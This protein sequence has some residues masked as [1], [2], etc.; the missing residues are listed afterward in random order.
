M[1]DLFQIYDLDF[2]PTPL[3]KDDLGYGLKGMWLEV[4][5]IGQ[6]ITEH[7]APGRPGNIITGVRDA[8]RDMSVIA[9]LESMNSTDYL[10]K[11]DRVYSFF[12][13]LG[14]FYITESRQGNKLMKV[15]VI[16]QYTPERPGGIQTLTILD[17]PLKIDG[18]PYWIS[19]YTTMNLHNNKGIPANGNWSFGMNLDVTPDNLIY[20]YENARIFNIYNAGI[21]LKTIQEKDNCEI[22]IDIKQNLTNFMVY[23][24]T[25]RAWEYNAVKKNDW[26][27]KNGDVIIFNGHD[28][29]LNGTTIMERTNR[30]YPIIKKGI[31][32]FEIVGLSSF[33][34]T[35]DFRF[36]YN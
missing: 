3:P 32:K 2:N 23:D 31:N 12:K 19:R 18:H 34:I 11:R 36:K 7:S 9:W 13:D 28:V 10:L 5:S 6:E 14:A 33:Q 24:A 27:L 26:A 29:R 16:D 35:F 15:R 17:I 4:S 25:G 20:Q 22:R 1:Q 8:E 21:L 30:Y